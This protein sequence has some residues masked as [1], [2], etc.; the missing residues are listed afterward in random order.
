MGNLPVLAEKHGVSTVPGNS[1]GYIKRV[2]TVGICVYGQE[3]LIL[4]LDRHWKFCPGDWDFVI[5]SFAE[6]RRGPVANGI[7]NLRRHTSL[8]VGSFTAYPVLRWPDHE[9]RILFVLL[10]LLL[11]VRGKRVVTSSKFCD[12]KWVVFERILEYDRNAYL[13]SVLTHLVR[14]GGF[15]L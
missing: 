2:A 4:R 12:A 10:P 1:A 15:Y 5:A 14:H 6:P 7:L 3:Y 8:A 11:R 13:S 9:S